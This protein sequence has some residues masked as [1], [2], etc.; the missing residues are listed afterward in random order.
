M[1]ESALPPPCGKKPD[2]GQEPEHRGRC[3]ACSLAGQFAITRHDTVKIAR[4]S[5]S[6]AT[7]FHGSSGRTR[8]AKPTCGHSAGPA[9]GRSA[10]SAAHSSRAR[11][12][13]GSAGA[14]C[15]GG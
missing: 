3:G 10:R 2:Q 8:P 7:C 4:A 11:H 14:R 12:S 13:A 1:A 9:D 6:A 5:C 15:R